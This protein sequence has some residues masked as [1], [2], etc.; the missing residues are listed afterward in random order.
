MKYTNISRN[1]KYII[2]WWSP[3]IN[4][5]NRHTPKNAD[6]NYRLQKESQSYA[7]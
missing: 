5:Q 1:N 4:K 3:Q 7:L 2:H 6:W